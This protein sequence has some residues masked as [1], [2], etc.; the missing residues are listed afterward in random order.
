PPNLGAGEVVGGD[1][2]LGVVEERDI[3]PLAIRRRGRT[4]P[5]VELVDRFQ[6]RLQD[7]LLPEDFPVPPI[8]A[9]EETI[10]WRLRIAFFD[11]RGY[12]HAVAG[13][14]RRRMSFPGNWR[15]PDDI[16]G[17]RPARREADLVGCAVTVW[18]AP[19]GPVA[20]GGNN[21]DCG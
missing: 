8:E 1:H 17:G 5:T 7:G 19:S 16:F 3:D 6:R 14:D 12:K 18:A 15:L 10:L 21:G 2:H 13:G 20:V 9:Q 11:R 4:R